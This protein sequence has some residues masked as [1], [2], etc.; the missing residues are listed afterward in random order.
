MK[1][2]AKDYIKDVINYNT[3]NKDIT[4]CISGL[5]IADQYNLYDVKWWII[6]TLHFNFLKCV[7]VGDVNGSD[8]FKTLPF[9]LT[10][11][12]FLL[13]GKKV[14]LMAGAKWSSP[15]AMQ[16]FEAF[17]VWLSKN[18]ATEEQKNEIWIASTLRNS[19]WRS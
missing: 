16:R 7:Q 13:F 14:N 8:S 9:N 18:E 6:L 15:T 10:K 3:M 4:E 5:K 2:E 12:V 11:D 17:M 1:A 19:L